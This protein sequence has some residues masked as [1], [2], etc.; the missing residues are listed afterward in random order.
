MLASTQFAALETMISE[1]EQECHKASRLV[2]VLASVSNRFKTEMEALQHL[3]NQ[4]CELEEELRS[5]VVNS[6][7]AFAHASTPDFSTQCATKE[8]HKQRSGNA[9]ENMLQS[10][11]QSTRWNSEEAMEPQ[12]TLSQG[13]NVRLVGSKN[14]PS[15]TNTVSGTCGGT[16]EPFTTSVTPAHLP[17][18]DPDVTTLIVRRIPRM[19]Q[20]SLLELW[21]PTW[22]YNFFYL[23]YNIKQRRSVA[24]AFI[25]FVSNEAAK[26]FYS[27]WEEQNITVKGVSKTLSVRAADIQGVVPNVK[28]LQSCGIAW[29]NNG[30][31]L[32]ALFHGTERLNFQE[33]LREMKVQTAM[34]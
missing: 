24:Y 16:F 34:Q 5:V 26:W 30:N 15:L 33:V 3:K 17:P 29:V 13:C 27:N 1:C 23:P 7:D 18:L 22:G 11:L 14:P 28:H 25:N 20:E 9:S 12:S 10:P 8:P 32:P 2:S 19:S 6:T 21:P 4:G 31:H